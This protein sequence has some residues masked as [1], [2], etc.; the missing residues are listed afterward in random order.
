MFEIRER[1]LRSIPNHVYWNLWMEHVDMFP[2]QWTSD[3]D[4]TDIIITI[5]NPLPGDR[6]QCI[7]EDGKWLIVDNK[8]IDPMK[9]D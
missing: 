5:L 2:I 9:W 4:G 6:W 3:L 1:L 8:Y 7:D